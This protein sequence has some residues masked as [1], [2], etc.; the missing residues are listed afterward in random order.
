MLIQATHLFK[1]RAG[2]PGEEQNMGDD[3]AIHPRA[4]GSRCN[5]PI[6][7]SDKHTCGALP[8]DQ[9]REG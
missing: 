2:M 8:S 9:R 6:S 5:G 7:C 3:D 1:L 4:N